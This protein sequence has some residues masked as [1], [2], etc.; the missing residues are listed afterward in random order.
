MTAIQRLTGQEQAGIY[1]ERAADD[2]RP[3][4]SSALGSSAARPQLADLPAARGAA[5]VG[6]V[7]AVA[8]RRA[9]AGTAD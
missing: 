6:R 2:L 9:V 8:R 1:N 5:P 3:A 7:A 4:A